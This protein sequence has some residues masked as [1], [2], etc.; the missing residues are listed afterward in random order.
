MKD[1]LVS[2]LLIQREGLDEAIILTEMGNNLQRTIAAQIVQ[3]LNPAT[4]TA[5]QL[6]AMDFEFRKSMV[7]R[8]LELSFDL[9]MEI[10]RVSSAI[11]IL[12]QRDYI[13]EVN[14]VGEDGNSKRGFY[15]NLPVLIQTGVIQHLQFACN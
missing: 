6:H 5:S 8:A 9:D 11:G 3:G 1:L 13:R 15:L 12:L 10:N 14:W 7:I 2:T 4:L